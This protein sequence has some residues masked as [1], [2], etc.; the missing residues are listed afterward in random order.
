MMKGQGCPLRVKKTRVD[1]KEQGSDRTFCA[2]HGS[3]APAAPGKSL[4]LGKNPA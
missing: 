3:E 1:S 4:I 2:G